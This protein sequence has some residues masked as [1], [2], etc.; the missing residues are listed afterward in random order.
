MRVLLHEM[1]SGTTLVLRLTNLFVLT[2]TL[3]AGAERQTQRHS[4]FLP[5]L[6]L[7]CGGTNR[8]YAK[9][10]PEQNS[11]ILYS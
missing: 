3:M 7:L 6:I 1:Y 11:P 5:P 9:V 10:G 2:V 4:I 8:G